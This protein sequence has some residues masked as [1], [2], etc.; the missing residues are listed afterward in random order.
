MNVKWH[1]AIRGVIVLILSIAFNANAQ[2]Q[3]ESTKL[4]E[5]LVA[6]DSEMKLAGANLT[7]MLKGMGPDES[8][9]AFFSVLVRERTGSEF[10]KLSIGLAFHGRVRDKNDQVFAKTLI[11]GYAKSA[12][13]TADSSLKTINHHMVSLRS[14]AAIS[15]SQKIRDI[16][17]KM[18]DEIKRVVQFRGD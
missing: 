3:Q 6:G 18:R 15:E 17:I 10:E 13:E 7:M 8:R 9:E 11:D 1:G 4:M 16:V 5:F 14:P 2:S 12:I